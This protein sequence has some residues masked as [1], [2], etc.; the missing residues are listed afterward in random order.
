MQFR[1]LKYGVYLFQIEKRSNIDIDLS[2]YSNGKLVESF[3]N[4]TQ[5]T[6]D[7]QIR[8]HKSERE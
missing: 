1:T 6:I 4:I 3:H 2:I 5:R 8:K 7:E